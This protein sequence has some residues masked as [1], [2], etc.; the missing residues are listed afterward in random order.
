MI[1]KSALS[2]TEL[3]AQNP[4]AFISTQLCPCEAA[5][6]NTRYSARGF[7]LDRNRWMPLLGDWMLGP[8]P[9]NLSNPYQLLM[10]S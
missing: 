2:E 1:R 8:P 7:P 5:A 9:A 3:V 4:L 6:M 10:G